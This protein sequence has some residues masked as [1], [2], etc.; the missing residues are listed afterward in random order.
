M[1]SRLYQAK[2]LIRLALP[3]L[4][5]QVAQTMMGFIDTVMAGRVSATDMAAVAVGTSI[6]LPAILFFAGIL[7]ALTPMV[8]HHHG[9]RQERKIRP[10][11]HQG[12]YLSLICGA[13]AMGLFT[14][15]EWILAQMD[16]DPQLFALSRDY[17]SAILWG[18]P[19]FLLFQVLRNFTEGLSWTLPSMVIGFVGLAINIPANYIF[20]YGHFGMPAMGG[21]GCGVATALVFWGMFLAMAL[22][23]LVTRR[24]Q[25]YRLFQGWRGLNP[26]LQSAVIRLGLP[27]ALAL[28]FE[29]TLFA[30]VAVAIAPL[31]PITVA[32][33]QVAANFSGLIF[34]LPLALGMALT[35]RVGY[36]L[37]RGE[38]GT[39]AMVAR[40]GLQLGLGIALLTALFTVL[41]REQIARLYS[42]DVEVLSLASQL[43]LL[44]ALY[45]LSDTV[46]VVTAATLRGY[47]DTT[48]LLWIS[49]IAYW[50]I[51]LTTGLVLGLTD[52]LVPAM[53]AAGFWV[54]F[55]AGLS[56]AALM[57]KIRLRRVQRRME[58]STKSSA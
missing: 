11:I 34:M 12:V 28:F 27:I 44:C 43:M 21:A 18:A 53:G 24:F 17:L 45:Q 54:G 36:Y 9:A 32:G 20:I 16:L 42:G 2:S 7:M 30:V 49:L 13:L 8:A 51:G 6:W 15:A 14:Q 35:I 26:A 4:A 5:A 47:K 19:P 31:G 50:G 39:A 48:A 3:V 58:L 40:I 37:G 46:Q 41:C 10:L 55:I 1:H 38:H 33:H 23:L 57:L 22:Y 52:W 25:G 56:A 29:V